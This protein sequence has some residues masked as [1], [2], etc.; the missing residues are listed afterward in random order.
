MDVKVNDTS[1]KRVLRSIIKGPKQ[2][3]KINK[4]AS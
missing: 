3:S 2:F 4:N 1:I